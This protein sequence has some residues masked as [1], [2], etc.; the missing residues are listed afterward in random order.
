[1]HNE[2]DPPVRLGRICFVHRAGLHKCVPILLFTLLLGTLPRLTAADVLL[3]YPVGM[4]A[5]QAETVASALSRGAGVTVLAVAQKLP[6]S[7]VERSPSPAV[8][9]EFASAASAYKELALNDVPRLLQGIEERCVQSA[10]LDACRSVLFEAGMLR[11]MAFFAAGKTDEASLEF[12]SAHIA[13]PS[14]IPDPKRY[15]PNILRAFAAAC[16]DLEDAP[17]IRLVVDTTPAEA[18]VSVD[19]RE[20]QS[21]EVDLLPGRHVVRARLAGFVDDVR[22]LDLRQED[23]LVLSLTPQGDPEAWETLRSLLSDEHA[24]A[25]DAALHLL[26]RRFRID[27]VILGTLAD[28]GRKVLFRV[29]KTGA[30]TSTALPALSLGADTIPPSFVEGAGASLGIPLTA[31]P[32]DPARASKSKTEAETDAAA[33]AE[34]DEDGEDIADEDE[35]ED[36]SIQYRPSGEEARTAKRKSILKSPWFWISVAAVTAVVS[37]VVIGVQ[38]ER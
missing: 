37:G 33:E 17:R 32:L 25:N 4:S 29:Q 8:E 1:M 35:D 31:G 26:I 23:R 36:P 12:Q 38:M 5:G 19:G 7:A 20:I 24:S 3:M 13:H 6:S 14:K 18:A 22:V 21:G 2:V 28:N 34:T 27:A 30:S 15:S 10:S 11:G 9:A 16:A